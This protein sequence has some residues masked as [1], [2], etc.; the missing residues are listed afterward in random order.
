MKYKLLSATFLTLRDV[1]DQEF[2][3]EKSLYL[4]HSVY[5]VFHDVGT[6]WLEY[7]DLYRSSRQK[8]RDKYGQSV[9]V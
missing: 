7:M 5:I 1:A 6:V 2:A 9:L 4:C 3:E 8:L